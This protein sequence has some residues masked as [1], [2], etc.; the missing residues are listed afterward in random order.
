MTRWFSPYERMPEIGDHI[1]VQDLSG[2]EMEITFFS[3]PTDVGKSNVWAW[4]YA[5]ERTE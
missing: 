1:V 5:D 4:R 2:E 3:P